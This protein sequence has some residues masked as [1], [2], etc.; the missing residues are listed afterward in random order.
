MDRWADIHNHF[1]W[2]LFN[3]GPFDRISLDPVPIPQSSSSPS[4]LTGR[5]SPRHCIQAPLVFISHLICFKNQC[6]G[7]HSQIS[8]GCPPQIYMLTFFF[9]TSLG[10]LS[11]SSST[12]WSQSN[13]SLYSSNQ[14]FSPHLIAST[15]CS[16]C[17][18]P[19][20]APSAW[21]S[22]TVL[23]SKV[24]QALVLRTQLS[25]VLQLPPHSPLHL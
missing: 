19:A 7:A 24:S 21:F 25:G 8:P 3:F 2:V 22:L 4:S 13:I 1:H 10:A 6:Y 15:L 17:P 5:S 12:L 14:G 16:Q 23:F 20:R 11:G 18:G 9:W